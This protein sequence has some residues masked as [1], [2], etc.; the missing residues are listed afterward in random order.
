MG[1]QMVVSSK[2]YNGKEAGDWMAGEGFM[3]KM[4]EEGEQ[5]K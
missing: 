2:L 1:S 3:K 5:V 4:S